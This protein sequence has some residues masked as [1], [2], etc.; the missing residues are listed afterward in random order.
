VLA[1][2]LDPALAPQ[3]A[4]CFA[5]PDE[6]VDVESRL[7]PQDVESTEM[8][9]VFP[10]GF[11]SSVDRR[12][13]ACDQLA[14]AIAEAWE[15]GD[16]EASAAATKRLLSRANRLGGDLGAMSSH[17]L[18]SVRLIRL[19]RRHGSAMT[20]R[21]RER[22]AAVAS[23]LPLDHAE[24][25]ELVVE[26]ARAGDGFLADALF[27]E[28]EQAPD[29]TRSAVLATR[30]ADVIDEASSNGARAVAIQ[31]L[32]R[33]QSR[34]LAIPALRRA[35]RLPS[36]TVRARALRSLVTHEPPAVTA[37]ELTAVLK[38]LVSHPLPDALE[39]EDREED[40]RILAAAIVGALSHVQPIEAEEAFLDLIDAEQDTIWLDA[41]W[42]T[43]A[44]A[45]AFPETGAVMVDHWLKCART[46]ER[47]NALAALRRLPDELAEPRLRLAASDPAHCVADA[48]RVQYLDRFARA[49]P[50]SWADLP[51]AALLLGQASERFLSRLAV[52]QGRVPEARRA[53]ARALWAEPAERENLVLLLQLLADDDAAEPAFSPAGEGP[54]VALVAR[55]GSLGVEGLCALATRFSEP[56]SFGWMRRLGDLVERRLITMDQAGPVRALAVAHVSSADAGRLDDSMRLLAQLGA[57]AEL[58][59]SILALALRDDLGSR[60]ARGVLV[61]W[62]DRSIDARLASEMAL[63]LADRDWWRLLHAARVSLER[64]SPAGR[65]IAQRVIEVAEGEPAAVDAAVE[66]ARYLRASGALGDAWALAALSRCESPVFAVAAHAWRDCAAVRPAL[67]VALGSAERCGASAVQAALVLLQSEPRLSPRD[68]RLPVVLRTAA[69]ADRAMLVHSMC[70]CG[71][72]LSVVGSHLEELFVSTDSE[73]T[74]ALVGIALWL[75]SSAARA[76]LR[77]LLPK[78][79]DPDLR[80]DVEEALGASPESYWAD[81]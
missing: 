81:G 69:P 63:A 75:K 40:E 78:I 35:L 79:V 12:G 39:D 54:A 3:F 60:D 66:C 46:H 9:P 61:R 6:S 31:L 42:A 24:V 44:L 49:C 73:V 7:R 57:P 17:P 5:R 30:L 11:D 67:E 10:Q 68:R 21:Q 41:A 76:L 29:W 38:D 22:A 18:E 52:V 19:F 34:A 25:E 14:A 28:D 48:A 56:E 8:L 43:E 58:F 74:G 71:A 20:P 13:A 1:D 65:V 72:P 2:Q 15:L 27:S 4:W 53:M 32:E 51:G 55:F 70:V 26:V 64:G 23:V 50:V 62:P 37:D 47:M 77:G 16:V 80:A 45:V 33:L 59:E 36:L